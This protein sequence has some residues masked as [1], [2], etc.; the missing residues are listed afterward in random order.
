MSIEV[1]GKAL[2]TNLYGRDVPE[3][4][5]DAQYFREVLQLEDGLTDTNYELNLIEEARFLGI[6]SILT[7]SNI[8]EL[9]LTSSQD[10]KTSVASTR[11]R[12][13]SSTSHDSTSTDLT[14]PSSS[15]TPRIIAESVPTKEPKI[16]INPVTTTSRNSVEILSRQDVKLGLLSVIPAHFS[17]SLIPSPAR[18]TSYKLKKI[19][20]TRF[21]RTRRNLTSVDL[22]H[23]CVRCQE[24]LKGTTARLTLVCGHSLCDNCT[25]LL[26]LQS[27]NDDAGIPSHL[28]KNDVPG[29]VIDAIL[30]KDERLNFLKSVLKLSSPSDLRK[31]CP[32]SAC[33]YQPKI[34]ITNEKRLST[35][36]DNRL[37]KKIVRSDISK[38]KTK[39]NP[40]SIPKERTTHEAKNHS[41]KCNTAEKNTLSPSHNYVKQSSK[42]LKPKHEYSHDLD[43]EE[44]SIKREGDER[45][46]ASELIDAQNRTFERSELSALH[47]RQINERDRFRAFERKMK[48]FMLTR[49]KQQRKLTLERH[50]TLFMRMK[51]RNMK[52]AMQLEDSQVA[53]EME[54]RASLMLTE[55]SVRTR[56]RHMEAYCSN[57]GRNE[58]SASSVPT[59]VVTERDLKELGQQYNIQDNIPQLHQSKI[60][61]LR[62]KQAKRME[63]LLAQQEHDLIKLDSKLKEEVDVLEKRFAAELDGLS[64]LFAVRR[65]NIQRKLALEEQIERKKLEIKDNTVILPSPPIEWPEQELDSESELE[66]KGAKKILKAITE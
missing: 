37:Q 40:S 9:H 54:L 42:P 45:E 55:Q 33:R 66:T 64:E 21:H 32:I 23:S 5:D 6:K 63:Q 13:F 11:S 60:N 51:E 19:L 20:R 57:V 49:Q 38:N 25:Q 17:S 58:N 52:I 31:L 10:S 39:L 50:E 43:N 28:L 53:A 27:C 18:K 15:K 3:E 46:I 62:E 30:S 34:S 4:F 59:R 44:K 61:I 1:S 8:E 65:A 29:S 14:G 22:T 41:Y 12:T 36:F 2:P 16:R 35:D 47:A 48:W 24:V 7:D 56:L 26:V